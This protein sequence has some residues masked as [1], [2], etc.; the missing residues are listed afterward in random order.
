M[1]TGTESSND[2]TVDVYV[3]VGSGFE[4]ASASSGTNYGSG[5]T[6]VESCYAT[7]F[8]LQ[9]L[10]PSNNAWTGSILVSMDGGSTYVPAT[11]TSCDAGTSTESI[12]VDGNDDGAGQAITQCLNGATCDISMTGGTSCRFILA[13]AHTHTD[14]LTHT[15][16]HVVTEVVLCR[17]AV[18]IVT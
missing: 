7:P 11:C 12:V 3:D 18:L 8:E 15:R 14:T 16:T 13:F 10:N 9:V 5:E 4:L 6:V 17:D 2:G 1:T